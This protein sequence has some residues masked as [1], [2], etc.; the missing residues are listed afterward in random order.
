MI[1]FG[2][3]Q[4]ERRC[5]LTLECEN[6]KNGRAVIECHNAIITP[7]E[8]CAY[9]CSPLFYLAIQNHIMEKVD[10]TIELIYDFVT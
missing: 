10:K 1:P 8:D 9:W 7:Q 5:Y 2:S 3:K 6:G 4:A